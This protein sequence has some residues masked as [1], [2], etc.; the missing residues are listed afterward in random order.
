MLRIIIEAE[1]LFNDET[2]TFERGHGEVAID[3]EHSLVSVSKWESKHKKPFLSTGDR[4]SEEV[5]DYIRAMIVSEVPDLEIVGKL[6]SEN[7][8][9]IQ[10]YIDSTESATTF[11][12]SSERIGSIEIITSELVYYWMVA[13]GIPFECE[14]WHLNRLLALIRICKIKNSKPQMMSRHEA[15]Q[16]NRAL[17]EQRKKELNT[18]G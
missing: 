11:W 5:F 3:L 14:N 15:A 4:S 10:R 8:D 2:Q 7:I 1:E 17:N 9:Q 13:F 16:R 18:K 6:S 12:I